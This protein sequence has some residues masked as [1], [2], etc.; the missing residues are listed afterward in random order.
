MEIELKTAIPMTP[1]TDFCLRYIG[2]YQIHTRELIG[3]GALEHEENVRKI[4]S[5]IEPFSKRTALVDKYVN[6]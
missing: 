2:V 3:C 6:M 5:H 4:V 1:S